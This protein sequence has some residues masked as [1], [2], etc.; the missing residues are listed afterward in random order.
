MSC[1]GQPH[2]DWSP[3]L[4]GLPDAVPDSLVGLRQF[5]RF[6]RG[7]ISDG[8]PPWIGTPKPK[9]IEQTATDAA[10]QLLCVLRG[11]RSIEE[12][13][14]KLQWRKGAFVD[15]LPDLLR[16]LGDNAKWKREINDRPAKTLAKKIGDG[17][18]QALLSKL[19]FLRWP[20]LLLSL[21]QVH[22]SEPARSKAGLWGEL[23]WPF[24]CLDPKLDKAISNLYDSI[25]KKCGPRG[26]G[27]P[28]S[29]ND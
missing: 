15:A 22:A 17:V 6:L 16:A 12:E 7:K 14:C 27:E 11:L 1:S 9:D 5:I 8:L 10:V 20:A 26:P 23:G 13:G 4:A 29:S 28:G 3:D 18:L 24:V 19:R 21:Q 2:R 25:R